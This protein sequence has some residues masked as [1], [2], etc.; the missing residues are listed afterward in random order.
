M[1]LFPIGTVT[2]SSNQGTIEGISYSMFEPNARCRSRVIFV[3][4]S[5]TYENVTMDTREKAQPN[6]SLQFDY[7]G[8]FTREFRQLEHF[9]YSVRA[10]LTPFYIVDFSQGISPSSVTTTS[11][12]VAYL[13]NTRLF[14]TVSNYKA[15]WVFFWNASAWKLGQVST[16]STNTYI[17]C[18]VSDDYGAMSTEQA[19][20]VTG[21]LKTLVYPV[22]EVHLIGGIDSFE[23]QDYVDKPVTLTTDGGLTYSGKLMFTSRYKV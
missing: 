3:N 4:L 5:V 12:W 19:Q 7:D 21:N 20:I 11:N 15:N 10:E 23:P 17:S 18:N 14:S 9:I 8:I 13:D 6:L 2:A 16:V 1:E 22:Y